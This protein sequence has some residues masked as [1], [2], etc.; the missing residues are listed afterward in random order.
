M[1]KFILAGL[2]LVM[3]L[4]MSAAQ[5]AAFNLDELVKAAQKEGELTA[6][7]TSS[8]I[9]DVGANFEKKYGIKVKG[10]KMADP[11][12]AERIIREVDAKNVQVDVIG[13][14]DGG[15]LEGKLIPDGYVTSWVPPDLKNS[16]SPADQNPLVFLWQPRIFGF[17]TDSYGPTTPVTNVW[18]M[19][20]PKWKGKIIIRDPAMTPAN[21]AF[22]AALT[23]DPKPLADAYKDLYGKNLV[24]KEANAGWEFLKRLFMN[25]IIV[26]KSD[27]DIGDAVGAAGQKDAPIGFYTMTK[28]R[29]NEV[30]NLKLATVQ[31]MKP[32]MGYALPTYAL[33]VKNAPHPNAAKLFI[34]YLLSDGHSP[35]TVNDMGGFSSNT[36]A[37]AHK[38]NEGTWNV[39]Q[40]KLVRLDNKVA[41]KLRQDIL[42]FWLENSGN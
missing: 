37:P 19:T 5:S 36:G 9:K 6:Y 32:F 29:D 14:E 20:E 18:Q 38:D 10:T 15:L 16:I 2:M 4:A 7:F 25:D 12:Q 40:P 17:N 31:G 21:L 27:G 28:Q 11:E 33:L 22:F 24:T 13:F 41:L 1:K 30:K 39:W 3:A 23:A 35:W 34:H 26:M 42:D 8:R